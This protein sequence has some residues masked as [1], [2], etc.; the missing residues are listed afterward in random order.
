MEGEIPSAQMESSL[1]YFAQLQE[2]R[3]YYMA[4]RL[5]W[6]DVGEW[7]LWVALRCG[8]RVGPF[9][10]RD[11]AGRVALERWGPP[12]MG[13]NYAIVRMA[14]AGPD[15]ATDPGPV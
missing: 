8:E 5:A 12:S 9:E 13:R 4:N 15:P 14:A 6:I 10:S 1:S 2:E 3:A 11:L 7:G